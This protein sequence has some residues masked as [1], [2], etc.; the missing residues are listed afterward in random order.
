LDVVAVLVG[1]Q[2]PRQVGRADSQ[3]TKLTRQLPVAQPGINQQ[4]AAPLAEV[5]GIAAA[6]R[7]QSAKTHMDDVPFLKPQMSY[8][9]NQAFFH[10][11]M[12][13]YYTT[14]C[15][16]LQTTWP[17]I[18]EFLSLAAPRAGRARPLLCITL[19]L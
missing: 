16:A 6:A 19:Q 9:P 17:H 2:Q 12:M 14:S 15:A 18:C 3:L 4:M 10:G 11:A 13:A 1:Q 8:I 7:N 5:N